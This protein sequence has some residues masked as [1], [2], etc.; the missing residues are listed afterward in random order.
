[1]VVESALPSPTHRFLTFVVTWEHYFF[2]TK[3][4]PG[5]HCQKQW[6]SN[7]MASWETS[8]C[9]KC[10]PNIV[11]F[12]TTRGNCIHTGAYCV[13][14][15]SSSL[16]VSF[17]FIGIYVCA[18]FSCQET[19][20]GCR[21]AS[22]LFI[23]YNVWHPLTGHDPSLVPDGVPPVAT[24]KTPTL[25]WYPNPAWLFFFPDREICRIIFARS[26][27][28]LDKS[29]FHHPVLFFKQF[30]AVQLTNQPSICKIHHWNFP[31][32]LRYD[33]FTSLNSVMVPPPQRL[34]I[35][36]GGFVWEGGGC[37]FFWSVLPPNLPIK[38]F[39]TFRGLLN[40]FP[41]SFRC[42][43]L[44][45]YAHGRTWPPSICPFL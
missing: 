18:I 21:S 3:Y 20:S 45:S 44:H 29:L 23:F 26:Y 7:I 33:I 5:F 32:S 12:Q 42:Y 6:K 19:V 8:I 2:S 39:M 35:D 40:N 1:M 10:L 16:T 34:S 4:T 28:F 13:R 43:F 24:T 31:F 9:S 14:G 37:L 30:C 36:L 15:G 22:G 41:P 17:I 38:I 27:F 25:S 11:R